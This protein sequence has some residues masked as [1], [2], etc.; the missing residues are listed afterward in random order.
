MGRWMIT[1]ACFADAH[2]QE[3][4]AIGAATP[5]HGIGEQK[6]MPYIFIFLLWKLLLLLSISVLVNLN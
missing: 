2:G 1:K 4:L 5:P 6:Q 3:L